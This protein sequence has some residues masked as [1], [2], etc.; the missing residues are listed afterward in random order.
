MSDGKFE[1][2]KCDSFELKDVIIKN[3]K[4]NIKRQKVVNLKNCLKT[5]CRK[6][7]KEVWKTETYG[8]NICKKCIKENRK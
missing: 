6:C 7:K 2:I 5:I 8:Y 1:K 4:T 3:N